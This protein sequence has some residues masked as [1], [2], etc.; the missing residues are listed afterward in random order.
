MRRLVPAF[1][2]GLLFGTG[3]V[4]S[5]MANPAK[6]LN[7]FD[8]AGT[9]DPSLAFVMGGALIVTAI[10][11]RLVL[12]RAHPLIERR[13]HLPTARD[14][15]AR[16]LGGAALF[17]VGWGMSGFCPGGALPVIGT[18]RADVLL[19]VV[20]LVAGILATRGIMSVAG[21]QNATP[22]PPR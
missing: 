20:A 11:Y 14:V 6:V 1:L 16:L 13:F 4:I 22:L 17:G 3:I 9:W 2:I 15:D 5:S 8:F 19:F 18:A 10:G 7:F 21:K 12:A